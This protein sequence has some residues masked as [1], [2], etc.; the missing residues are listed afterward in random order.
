LEFFK[1][2]TQVWTKENLTD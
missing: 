2:Q 1:R